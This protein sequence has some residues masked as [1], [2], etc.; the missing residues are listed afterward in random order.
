MFINEYSFWYVLLSFRILWSII[1][2]IKVE[3]WVYVI[4][5][6]DYRGILVLVKNWSKLLFEVVNFCCSVLIWVIILI[7]IVVGI[8]RKI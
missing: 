7:F 8:W 4:I 1:K 5:D 6:S 2:D 3:I